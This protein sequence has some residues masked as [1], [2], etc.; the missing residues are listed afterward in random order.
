[1]SGGCERC[2]QPT[3]QPGRRFCSNQCHLLA[4]GTQR[5]ASRRRPRPPCPICG[6][7]NVAR[8]ATHCSRACSDAARRNAPAPCLRCGSTDRDGRNRRGPYCSWECFDEDRYQRTG[9]FARWMKAWLAG[10]VSGTAIKGGPDHRVRQALVILRGQRCEECSWDKV[11]PVSQRVPLHVDH[12]HGDRDRNRP[13]DVRL[14]C[15][16]CHAL[17]PNYQHLNNPGVQPIRKRQNR[18]YRETW[19]S[20]TAR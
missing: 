15:P 8:G 17:T 2:G 5:A 4:S 7:T 3:K 10:E 11:N 6:S 9:S 19:L 20:S 1:M 13:E 16:N 18:R 12:I 14:L